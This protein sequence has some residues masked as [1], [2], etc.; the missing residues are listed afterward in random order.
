MTSDTEKKYIGDRVKLIDF[1]SVTLLNGNVLNTREFDKLYD[2]NHNDKNYFIVVDTNQ[3]S[4]LKTKR[5]EYKQDLIIV[6]P[7]TKKFYRVFSL[8]VKIHIIQ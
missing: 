7:K 8:H 3:R 1:S 6:N 2:Y 5:R 4:I